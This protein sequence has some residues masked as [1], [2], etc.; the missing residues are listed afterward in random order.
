MFVDT[1]V[2][3]A[4]LLGEAHADALVECAVTLHGMAAST[5]SDLVHGRVDFYGAERQKRLDGLLLQ[6]GRPF[7]RPLLPTNPGAPT[8]SYRNASNLKAAPLGGL[9]PYRVGEDGRLYFAAKSE[10]YHASLGHGFEGYQLI[11]RARRLG[12]PNATHNNT[13][14]HVTRVLEQELVRCINGLSRHERPELDRILA[15]REGKVL[16]RVINLETGSLA[17]EA[18]VKMMLARFHRLDETSP[19]PRYAGRIPVF[20]VMADN[21]G[22]LEAN[23]HGTTL[24]TQLFRGLWPELRGK[25]ESQEILKVVAVRRNDEQDFA[26]KIATYNRGPFKTAGFLHEIIL[27]NYGGIRLTETYLQSAYRACE[28]TDTPTL[29]DEIQS[30][31][32]Y[33]GMFLFRQYG[34]RPDFVILGKGF[35][36]GEYPASKIV[37]TCGMDTLTQFGALVTNGQEELASLAYLVT[38]EFAQRN[39]DGIQAV[40]DH[41]E[42]RLRALQRDFPARIVRV[43][44]KGHL[45]AI[46]FGTVDE[47]VAFSLAMNE[48]CIDVSAQTYKANCPPAALLKPPII[49]T[50]P[51]VDFLCDAMVEILRN[52]EAKG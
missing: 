16:N 11:D 44:G 29:V 31:M 21:D 43:E 49:A 24:V 45:A 42:A 32:W 8:L 39:G 40:G 25:L 20:L 23:Y 17:V 10:H 14:G 27:M 13:R 6:V 9:G 34:L 41:F 15:S 5:A 30:C 4:D 50:G 12:V 19:E 7:L 18:G 48:R 26:E 22:G 37:T 36:G 51:M 1:A 28:A 47:A 46:H 2:S 35:P 3:L 38:M 33:K 52:M